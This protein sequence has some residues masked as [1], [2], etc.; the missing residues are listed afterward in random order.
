MYCGVDGREVALGK[1]D[2]DVRAAKDVDEE[3]MLDTV[4]FR[5]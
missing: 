4:R 5:S 1:C 3:D 2:N